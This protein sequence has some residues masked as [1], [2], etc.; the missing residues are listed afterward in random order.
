M[1]YTCICFGDLDEGNAIRD[2][3]FLPSP[4]DK[5][6]EDEISIPM[7]TIYNEIEML[8][9]YRGHRTAVGSLTPRS[10]FVRKTAPEDI[11]EKLPFSPTLFPI[12]TLK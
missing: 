6:L 8:K 7:K 2:R 10:L 1:G 4:L 9:Y 5:D 11:L 3:G 12:Q